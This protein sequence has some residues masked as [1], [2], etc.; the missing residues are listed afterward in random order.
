[1]EK[2]GLN[3]R[4]LSK[5]GGISDFFIKIAGVSLIFIV[6]L[7]VVDIILRL[8]KRPIPGTFELVA[9]SGAVV[10]GFS[11]P[12]TSWMR[13]HIYV[14]FF[15]LKFPKKIRDVFNIV[16]RCMGIFLFLITGWNLM[17]YGMSLYKTGEVS[18]S[19]QMPYYPIICAIGISCFI[20]CVVILCD[21]FNILGGRYE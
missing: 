4:F 12:F 8:L 7:T 13:G 2:K 3:E 16:T 1:M 18:L 5:V 19:L 21:I 6:C 10:V 20:T 14:D 9:F 15:I 11:L 17:K